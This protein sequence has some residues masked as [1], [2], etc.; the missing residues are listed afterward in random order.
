MVVSRLTSCKTRDFSVLYSKDL[1]ILNVKVADVFG[2]ERL[3][4]TS[5]ISPSPDMISTP[6]S[7]EPSGYRWDGSPA[8]PAYLFVGVIDAITRV[9]TAVF[10]PTEVIVAVWYFRGCP[11]MLAIDHK[12][13]HSCISLRSSGGGCTI[14]LHPCLGGCERRG[15]G[16]ESRHRGRTDLL[17][18]QNWYPLC[19]HERQVKYMRH[20]GLVIVFSVVDFPLHGS[21]LRLCLPQFNFG[22]R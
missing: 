1:T 6:R 4:R 19:A 14:Y 18:A 3:V 17:G 5:E 9:G 21:D 2:L 8:L 7:D 20:N 15:V 16:Q 12:H 13:T 11:N 22:F 10:P